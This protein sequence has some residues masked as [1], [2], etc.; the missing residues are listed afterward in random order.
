MRWT[1]N[2]S[3]WLARTDWCPGHYLGALG[4]LQNTNSPKEVCPSVLFTLEDII[5]EIA[6]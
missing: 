6:R 4:L 1:T 3:E 5:Y 2:V